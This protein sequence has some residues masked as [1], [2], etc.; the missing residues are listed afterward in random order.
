MMTQFISTV[1]RPNIKSKKHW[2]LKGSV[3]DL[4]WEL[5]TSSAGSVEV[6]KERSPGMPIWDLCTLSWSYGTFI[7]AWIYTQM[8]KCLIKSGFQEPEKLCV[9]GSLDLPA[10]SFTTALVE[11]LYNHGILRPSGLGSPASKKWR[12][13][14]SNN[15]GNS[16]DSFRS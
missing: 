3:W 1:S 16:M 13:W 8:I 12:R 6:W 2:I 11:G 4:P 10:S 7:V 9:P 5:G 15:P 14:R